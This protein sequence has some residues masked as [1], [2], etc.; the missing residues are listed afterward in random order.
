LLP[1]PL[2]ADRDFVTRLTALTHVDLVVEH[3][4]HVIQPVE[5]VNGT[6]VYWSVGNFISGMGTPGRDVFADPRTLD[7]MAAA[8][9]FTEQSPG[10]FSVE[11]WP[12][13][14]CEEPFS[15]A[16]YAPLA[17]PPNPSLPVIA[18]AALQACMQRSTAAVAG[19]H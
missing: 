7:E 16:V 8:A 4:P 18:G 13:L 14:L 17:S 12:V 19:L 5:L 10:V 15:R 1:A 2:P 6:W 11:P 3:G 9:R